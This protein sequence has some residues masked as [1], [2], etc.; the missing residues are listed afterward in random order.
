MIKEWLGL[1]KVCETCG[2]TYS[3]LLNN[4]C[5]PCNWELEVQAIEE[6]ITS[7]NEETR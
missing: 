1:N 2:S 5:F 4:K 7:L 6:G 3:Q